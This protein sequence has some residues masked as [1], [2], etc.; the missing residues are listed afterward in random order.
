MHSNLL[1]DI[2]VCIVSATAF[3]YLARLTR[4]PIL[5]GHILAGVVIGPA[6]LQ[7]ISEQET[8]QTLAELGLAFLLFI[9]GLEIDI[10]TLAAAGRPAAICSVVQVAGSAV[11]GWG[12]AKILGYSS[13]PAFYLGAAVAFSSTMVVVKLLSDRSELDTLAGRLTLGILL[14][15]DVLAIVV[16]AIQPNLGGGSGESPVVAMAFSIGKG[17]A[18]IA[19]SLAESRYV[20]PILFRYAA[21]SPEVLLVS[22]I[23]WCFI[24]CHSAVIA[25]FSIAM[26]ALIAGVSMSTFPYTLDVVAKIRSLRDFFVTLFFVSLGM[27]LRVP[28]FGTVGIALALSIVVV[29]TRFAT[30]LPLLRFLGYGNRVGFLSSIHLSQ[31][32]E[33]ALV[34]VLIGVSSPY[35]HV[36]QD[37]VSLVLLVLV[38]TSTL[39]TYLIDASHKVTAALVRAL[40]GT[41]FEDP[42]SRDFPSQ[43]AHAA[44]IILVGCFRIGASLVRELQEDGKEFE[45]IDFSPEIHS[46]LQKLGVRCIYGDLSHL[47][48]LEHAGISGA[49]VIVSSI[50]DDFLRGTSNGKLLAVL[51][52]VNPTAK[53]ILTADSLDTARELYASGADFVIVPRLIAARYLMR[54]IEGAE[55]GDLESMREIALSGLSTRQEVMP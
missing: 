32:S 50:P 28:N 44:P 7:L 23:S 30:I 14:M 16:L 13:L 46:N 5:L 17:F 26:G 36:G 22:A 48:T 12:S 52:K 11:A 18:L 31:I 53:I 55:L 15:Q 39:S 20:L 49:K 21:K 45:V 40:R 25:G 38:V 37:V 33:F 51:R 19:G 3:A 54:I 4:Q 29:V 34:I 2:G 47:D 24:V 35:H 42:Q 27:L 10:K 41:A 8:I 9:V 43:E 1:Q 6:G